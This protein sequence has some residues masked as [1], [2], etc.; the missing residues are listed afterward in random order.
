MTFPQGKLSRIAA[1]FMLCSLVFV[2]L[3]VAQF[4]SDANNDSKSKSETRAEIAP[5]P[6]FL[7]GNPTCSSIDSNFGELKLNFSAPNGSFPFAPGTDIS[8]DAGTTGLAPNPNLF[9]NV[10]SSGATMSSWSLSPLNQIDRFI[11]YII[12]KGGP[13]ANGYDYRPGGAIGDVGPFTTPGAAF[14]ISHLSFCFGPTSGPTSASGSITGRVLTVEGMGIGNTRIIAHNINSGEVVSVITNSFGYYTIEGLTVT[15]T[16]IV[17][18][19][20]R[21]MMFFNNQRTITLDDNL[22][23]IDFVAA[24]W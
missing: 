20:N 22:D 5:S 8:Y 1:A 7:P 2:N 9:L 24:S 3:T 21:K 11:Y 17:T 13:D 16:Y 10:F 19:E 23:G 4:K 15:D 14:E 18:A 12:V 6:T